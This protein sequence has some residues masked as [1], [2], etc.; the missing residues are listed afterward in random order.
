MRTIFPRGF[1]R[2]G[3]D[4]RLKFVRWRL[5]LKRMLRRTL[6]RRRQIRIW[7][8]GLA[9]GKVV[10]LGDV[11]KIITGVAGIKPCKRCQKRARALNRRVV[12]SGGTLRGR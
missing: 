7:M 2:F 12:L 1:S 10:G 5:S 8:P 3:R 4:N 9:A 11:I 6:R